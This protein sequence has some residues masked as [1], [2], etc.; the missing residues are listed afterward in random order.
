MVRFVNPFD[1]SYRFDHDYSDLQFSQVTLVIL[2]VITGLILL[3]LFEM[4]LLK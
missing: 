2:P 1:L 4:G 3:K